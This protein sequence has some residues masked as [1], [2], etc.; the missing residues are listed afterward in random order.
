MKNSCSIEFFHDTICSF[1]FP[2]S[3]KMRKVKRILPDISI[4][5]RSFALVRDEN[6]FDYMFNSRVEAKEEVLHHWEHANRVDPLHRFNIEG[7]RNADFPFPIS[8]PALSACKAAGMIA[9]ED[10]YWDL[11]DKLQHSFF[12]DSLNI[13]DEE[14]IFKAVQSTLL[15]FNRWNE[16]YH[17]PKVLDR[18][19]VV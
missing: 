19:S 1:C 15:D 5:H 11:F 2:M 10:G 12:V 16:M 18:K 6:D 7:M 3:Y 14:V 8:L 4:I 13:Q 9:G 17:S